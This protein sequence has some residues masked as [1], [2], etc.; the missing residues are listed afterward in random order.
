[1][2]DINKREYGY[3]IFDAD[4]TLIDFD[5]DE[6]RAL[7]RAFYVA[8]AAFTEET[9]EDLW[10]FS[11]ENWGRLG[12]YNVH[13]PEIQAGY[14]ALYYKHVRELFCYADEKYALRGRRAE[15]ERAFEETLALPAHPIEGAEEVVRALAERYRVCVATN[16]LT[17]LQTGRLSPFAPFLFR[18][19]ISEEIGSIKPCGAFFAAMLRSL[20]ARAEECLFVGDSLGSDIAG[21]RGAGMECV[22]FNRRRLPLPAEFG[23]TAQIADLRELLA[24]L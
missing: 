8:G 14:H 11:A 18:V 21:A 12:L 7:R 22:W 5:E 1:M 9:I 17:R 13:L 6:K 23:K 4:H 10:R 19:F 15:A 3:I 20:G 24:L 16:G 2:A